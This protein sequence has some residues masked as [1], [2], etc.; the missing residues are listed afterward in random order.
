MTDDR[1]NK[2]AD[3]V[4]ER[5]SDSP[6]R[7]DI[8]DVRDAIRAELAAEVLNEEV[9]NEF[10]NQLARGTDKRHTKRTGSQQMDL[11][12][13][14]VAA[15]EAVWKVG[16]GTRVT[17]RHAN[18]TDV[19]MW[20]S[21]RGKNA[22]KVAA[23]FKQDRHTAAELLVYMPD[24]LTTVEE[25]VEVRKKNKPEDGAEQLPFGGAS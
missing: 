23:A 12:T 21:I 10:A 14:E 2:I 5:Y 1:F 13:G 22:D 6:D 20:L 7:F 15:L 9:L 24:D 3:A 4:Y 19:L 8:N 16:G 11:L 25:A 17:A 18:R